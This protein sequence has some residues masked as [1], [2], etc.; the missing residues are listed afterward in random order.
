M[1]IILKKDK[2]IR[3][4]LTEAE[5]TVDISDEVAEILID[6]GSATKASAKAKKTSKSED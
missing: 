1:K 4:I 6:E 3:G 5:T 2:F